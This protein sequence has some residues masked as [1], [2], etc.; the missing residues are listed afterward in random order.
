[1]PFMPWRVGP[2]MRR[3]L[4]LGLLTVLLVAPV[5]GQNANAPDPTATSSVLYAGSNNA[6]DRAVGW[7]N[8]DKADPAND[9]T[10]VGGAV[11]TCDPVLG[12][13]CLPQTEGIDWTWT[14]TL[15]PALRAPLELSAGT[16]R[17]VAFLGA[18]TGTGSGIEVTTQLKQGTTVIADGP[19]KEHAYDGV[20]TGTPY[21][22]VTWDLDI[23]AAT[24]AASTPVV[25]TV[26]AVAAAGETE[27]NFFMSVSEARGRS[28]IELPIAAGAVT[29]QALPAGAVDVDLVLNET[30]TASYLYTW[31]SPSKAQAIEFTATGKGLA[32]L[33]IQGNGTD[34]SMSIDNGTAVGAS[35]TT[36]TGNGPW[37]ITIAVKGFNGTVRLTIGDPAASGPG[38]SGSTSGTASGSATSSAGGGSTAA[39][40]DAGDDKKDTPAPSLPLLV[41]LVA[42]A[43][44]L[45]R[46]LH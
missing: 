40:D 15:N 18:G 33:D 6:E 24:L 43:A 45:R 32:T 8:T 39:G 42:L 13:A 17:I 36:V 26:R 21:Q 16:L 20:A 2:G 35:R 22:S 46:R 12:A 9:Q 28:R 19:M 5:S 3:A 31:P 41:G 34:V 14:W 38:P 10:S 1:M 11:Q 30:T 29:P 23:P 37:N 7:M 25:W 44:I 27:G 4:A